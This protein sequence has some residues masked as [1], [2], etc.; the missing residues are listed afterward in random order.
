MKSNIKPKRATKKSPFF[1]H[2]EQIASHFSEERR[3]I[4]Q[5]S[6]QAVAD[7]HKLGIKVVMLTGDDEKAAKHMASLVGID[8]V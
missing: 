6:K 5:E 2:S 7:L 4:K 3:Q 1:R 8:D